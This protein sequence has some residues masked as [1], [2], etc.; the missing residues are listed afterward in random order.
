MK[1]NCQ[2]KKFVF[3][4]LLIVITTFLPFIVVVDAGTIIVPF[5]GATKFPLDANQDFKFLL[6]KVSIATSDPNNF[7][8]VQNILKYCELREVKELRFEYDNPKILLETAIG[9]QGSINIWVSV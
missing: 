4:L 2:I 1:Q 9:Q 5:D 7:V 3:I 8:E 6:V